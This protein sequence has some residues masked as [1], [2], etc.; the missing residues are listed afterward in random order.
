MLSLKKKIGIGLIITPIVSFLL[1]YPVIWIGIYFLGRTNGSE[2]V[3]KITG[4][5]FA[6]LSFITAVTLVFI[7]PFGIILLITPDSTTSKTDQ[8]K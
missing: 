8:E 3:A 6:I 1:R 2:E 7:L 4:Y 5:S